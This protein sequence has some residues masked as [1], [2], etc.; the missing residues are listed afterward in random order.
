[1][2]NHRRSS[3]IGSTAAPYETRIAASCGTASDYRSVG[4]PS[5]PNYIGATSGGTQGIVD[6]ASPSSHPLTV[7]NLFRQVRS[8]GGSARSYAE[9]MPGACV[10]TGSGR[11]AVKHNPAAYYEGGIDRSECR[12]EIV[13]LG[14][15]SGSF[16]TAVTHDELPT[17]TV[18]VPDLCDDTHNCPVSQGDR[19]LMRWLGRILGGP[20]YA[21]G[22]TVVFVV[23]DEPTPMPFLAIAPTIKGGTVVGIPIDHYALLRTTEDLLGLRVHLGTART[24]PSLRGPLGI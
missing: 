9:S 3:V 16:E 8:A 12:R 24:A 17:F 21:K 5:L 23:W 18:I 14:G 13:P 10:L 6:D 7:D 22:S 15:L 2:E 4:A 11:Y 19:W 20:T 1:M